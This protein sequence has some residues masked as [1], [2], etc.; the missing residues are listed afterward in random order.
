MRFSAEEVNGNRISLQVFQSQ[1][2]SLPSSI[3]KLLPLF[4]LSILHRNCF[5][6]N[7]PQWEGWVD[8]EK[9]SIFPF[10]L[11]TIWKFY[12]ASETCVRTEIVK[13]LAINLLISTDP[14]LSHQNSLI[15]PKTDG[16]NASQYRRG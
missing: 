11:C 5:F 1:L 7:Q 10:I 14:Y 8:G 16:K 12:T 13:T 4:F 9:P 3:D 2:I 15:I 6:T